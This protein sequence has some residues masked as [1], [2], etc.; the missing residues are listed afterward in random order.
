MY[1]TETEI[2]NLNFY[3]SIMDVTL[4]LGQDQTKVINMKLNGDYYH[5]NSLIIYHS[6]WEKA[7]TKVLA[8]V[9]WMTSCHYTDS[10][11]SYKCIKKQ[12]YTHQ[13]KKKKKAEKEEE[14]KRQLYEITETKKKN[15]FTL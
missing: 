3:L 13:K 15:L 6:P 8:M 11:V 7:N 14:K 4:K 10:H 9:F 1:D 5:A 2:D 12:N